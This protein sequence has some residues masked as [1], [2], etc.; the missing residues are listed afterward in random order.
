MKKHLLYLLIFP[1]FLCCSKDENKRNT[2]PFLPDYSFSII[3]DPDLPLYAELKTAI[4]PVLITSANVGVNGIFVIKISDTNFLAWEANC[5]NQYPSECSRMVKLNNT[6]AKCNCDGLEYSLLT[7]VGG[8][9]YTL[10]PYRVEI[11]G[12]TI[13]VYN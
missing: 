8:G 7:G 1:L 2:N 13:R 10:K 6:T 9:N 5:P 3:I 12:T 4:N 11:L